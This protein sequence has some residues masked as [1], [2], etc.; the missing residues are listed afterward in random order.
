M[1]FPKLAMLMAIGAFLA[2]SLPA[3][4][5]PI[6]CSSGNG[7]SVLCQPDSGYVNGTYLYTPTNPNNRIITW[8]GPFYFSSGLTV[9]SVPASWPSWNC[10]PPDNLNC[11]PHVLATAGNSLTIDSE[12]YD[13]G[14][15][16]IFGFD[17]L[18]LGQQTDEIMVKFFS[19]STL[20]GTIERSVNGGGPAQL[21]AAVRTSYYTLSN[22]QRVADM[23]FTSVQI[24]DLSGNGFAIGELRSAP[25]PSTPII[26]G[27]GLLILVGLMRRKLLR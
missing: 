4:A 14:G 19:G 2:A 25:E 16:K 11:T 15:A 6:Y 27:S 22:G 10:S 17:L 21:F 1:R 12:D 3:F 7:F 9:L 13:N 18:P 26:L 8:L 24:T 23:P 20:I 5:G